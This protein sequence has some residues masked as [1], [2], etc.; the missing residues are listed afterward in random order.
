M[1]RPHLY[2]S[3]N[4]LGKKNRSILI[5]LQSE[6]RPIRAEDFNIPEAG[7][8]KERNKFIKSMKSCIDAKGYVE[9]HRFLAQIHSLSN[10]KCDVETN[11]RRGSFSLRDVIAIHA[12]VPLCSN[13][14]PG[15]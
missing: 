12:V 3:Q 9:S 5:G 14:Y 8:E 1:P 15:D 13:G 11:R 6:S 2:P 10:E 4:A 7:V